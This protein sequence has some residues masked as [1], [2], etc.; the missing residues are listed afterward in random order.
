[1]DALRVNACDGI[2]FP[3]VNELIPDGDAQLDHLLAY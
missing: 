2:V 3:L 1:M